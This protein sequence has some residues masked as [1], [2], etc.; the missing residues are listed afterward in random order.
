[1]SGSTVTIIN[2]H[3]R[4]SILIVISSLLHTFTIFEI[5]RRIWGSSF[6]QRRSFR[7]RIFCLVNVIRLVFVTAFLKKFLLFVIFVHLY[8]KLHAICEFRQIAWCLIL[9]YVF[10]NSHNLI[11]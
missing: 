11:S 1:M 10:S 8:K 7:S 6:R 3:I 2:I 5:F 9:K 4:I